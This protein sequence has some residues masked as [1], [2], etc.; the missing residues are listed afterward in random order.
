[1]IKK[2][3]PKNK[4][5]FILSSLAI[6]FSGCAENG[7]NIQTPVNNSCIKKQELSRM[8]LQNLQK[9]EHN[10][11]ELR[12]ITTDLE[13]Y[14]KWLE[15]YLADYTKY[16]EGIGKL[17]PVIKMIPLP[18]AGQAG[19]FVKFG[20]KMTVSLANT[21][22]AIENAN[23]SIAKY[24]ELVKN[25]TN[26]E[27]V[28]LAAKYADEELVPNVKDALEKIDNLKSITSSLLA[29]GDNVDK[30]TNGGQDMLGKAKSI[31]S[32]NSDTGYKPQKRSQM[33]QKLDMLKSK[34]LKAEELSKNNALLAKRA[35]IY[36]EIIR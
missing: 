23:R 34:T 29:F 9:I 11:E 17:S 13:S 10:S 5:L 25:S 8:A 35:V 3:K 14:T 26:D 27:T 32:N 2:T 31:I 20:S 36:C 4:T 19:D 1:M 16:I 15:Y 28:N 7:H 6:I 22:V 12:M 24:Q 21:A 18:Y 30:V 33:V